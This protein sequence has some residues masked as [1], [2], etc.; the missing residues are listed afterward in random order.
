MGRRSSF[1]GEDEEEM[2]TTATL[3]VIYYCQS[4]PLLCTFLVMYS[5]LCIAIVVVEQKGKVDSTRR[6]SQFHDNNEKRAHFIV[7]Y[8]MFNYNKC[9][10]FVRYDYCMYLICCN[11]CT[12]YIYHRGDFS[13]VSHSQSQF[14]FSWRPSTQE[15]IQG[16]HSFFVCM[17]GR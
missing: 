7:V 10:C 6:D 14:I 4:I 15:K 5:V 1:G 17:M 11:K 3:Y 12:L 8:T 13:Q 9:T 16:Q 2:G